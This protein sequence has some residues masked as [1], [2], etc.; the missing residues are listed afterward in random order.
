MVQSIRHWGTATRLLEDEGRGEV[1]PSLLGEQLYQKW[2]PYLEDIVSLWLVHWLLVN[3]PTKAAA[4]HFA[5][6]GYPRREFTKAELTHHLAEWAERSGAK[7]K[8]STLERDIDCFIRTYL[9]SKA[10]KSGV[11]E[12]SFDCPLV[13]LGLLQQYEEG[14]RYGFVV[15]HKRTLP[16]H[17]FGYALID[18]SL[19]HI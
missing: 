17:I 18:L 2:D 11:A 9:P 6:F 12:D 8:T 15:G 13:E 7:N 14:E 1:K 19:I 16:P 5:F 10:S 3:N 4:W